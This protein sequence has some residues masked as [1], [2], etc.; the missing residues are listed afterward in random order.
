MLIKSK[1]FNPQAGGGG[2]SKPGG[3]GNGDT[4]TPALALVGAG[5]NS[6]EVREEM[7]ASQSTGTFGPELPEEFRHGLDQYFNQLDEWVQP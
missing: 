6:D 1:R 5:L 3:G 2:G 7:S 4:E